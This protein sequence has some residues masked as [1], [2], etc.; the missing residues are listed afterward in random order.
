MPL[1]VCLNLHTNFF[2][3]LNIILICSFLNVS[4][5]LWPKEADTNLHTVSLKKTLTED[6]DTMWKVLT[7]TMNRYPIDK[8]NYNKGELFSRWIRQ[9]SIWKDPLNNNKKFFYKI[10]IFL[11]KNKDAKTL[12]LE[13]RKKIKNKKGFLTNEVYLSSNLIEEKIILYR[14]IQELKIYKKNNLD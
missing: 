7:I 10:K 5:S 4:C 3:K 2:K 13:I 11:Q 9:N 1:A 8:I 12:S 6:Y 14:M